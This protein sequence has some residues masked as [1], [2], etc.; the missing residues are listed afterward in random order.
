LPALEQLNM[1]SPP[2]APKKRRSAGQVSKE[3]LLDA[4]HAAGGCRAEAARRL[5][6]S[7]VTLWKWLKKHNIQVEEKTFN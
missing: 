3:R 4:I 7:R 2:E 5:G 6:V 1:P